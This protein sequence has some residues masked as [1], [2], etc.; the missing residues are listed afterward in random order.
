M[1]QA[2]MIIFQY[3]L[4]ENLYCVKRLKL[5]LKTEK[6]HRYRTIA[7]NLTIENSSMKQQHRL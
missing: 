3:L 1:E 6:L 5:R 7:P 2:N 4:I